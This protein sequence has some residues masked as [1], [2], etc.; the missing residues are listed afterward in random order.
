[1]A[2]SNDNIVNL[3]EDGFDGFIT[4]N[5]AVLVDF[6]AGWCMPCIMQ[7]TLITDKINMFPKDL[8]IAKINVDEYPGIA[9][10]FN[11][12]GIPQMY[13]M[14]NGKPVKGWTGVTPVEQLIADIKKHI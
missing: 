6:W 3:T 9:R 2:G 12:M 8:R 14:V 5:K 11:I 7:G 1:M 10:R 13:L 4:E